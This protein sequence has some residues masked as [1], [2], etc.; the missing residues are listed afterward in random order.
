[1]KKLYYYF[2]VNIFRLN[3]KQCRIR[4]TKSFEETTSITITINGSS[5]D[6]AAWITDHSLSMDLVLWYNDAVN[7]IADKWF[8]DNE[9]TN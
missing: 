1:M 7:L 9:V 6:E 4:L 8:K 5:V 2:F 3:N